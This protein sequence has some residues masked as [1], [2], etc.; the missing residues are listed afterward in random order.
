MS[1]NVCICTVIY[2]ALVLANSP[3]IWSQMHATN[4]SLCV[5]TND[6]KHRVN[7]SNSFSEYENLS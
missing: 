6:V 7:L 2:K 4:L 5:H 3:I 1:S